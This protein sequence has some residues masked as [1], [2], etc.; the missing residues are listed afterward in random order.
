MCETA[1]ATPCRPGTASSSADDQRDQ[2]APS[3]IRPRHRLAARVAILGRRR[4]R[5]S[6]CGGDRRPDRDSFAAE[7]PSSSRGRAPWLTIQAV[8]RIELPG[9]DDRRYPRGQSRAR[10]RSPA[11]TPGSSAREPGVAG[12]SRARRCTTTSTALVAEL[13]RARRS[14]RDRADPRSPRPREAV[15]AAARAVSR[16]RRWP[17]AAGTSTSL[18]AR[19]RPFGPLE[20]VATP[21]HAPD[22]LAF[23]RRARSAL[24]GDAV[25]GEGSVFI[26]PDPG[27]L[28]GYLPGLAQAARRAARRCCCPGHGPPV[29]R[30]GGQARRVHRAPAGT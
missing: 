27:A 5:G 7:M 30:P 3:E 24:T 28:A 10:S 16:T 11:P 23:V 21:G 2:D 4:L 15:A 20:A 22:H 14:R 9:H 8:T 29:A 25:L 17:P 26:A 18:L 6:S 1:W 12:R 13:E 19:R